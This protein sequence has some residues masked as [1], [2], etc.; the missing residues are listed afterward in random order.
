MNIEKLLFEVQPH[1]L[2][3]YFKDLDS[4]VW[5]PWLKNQ[6]GFLAKTVTSVPNNFLEMK[7]FWRSLEDRKRASLKKKEM[8]D[9]DKEM[10]ERFPGSF[11]L[12][13]SS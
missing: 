4:R 12:V 1:S 3:G 11:S 9:L 8:K 7:I 5:D 13:E 2:L 6:P 10:I